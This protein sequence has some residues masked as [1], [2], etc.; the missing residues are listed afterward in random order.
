MA[1]SK[2]NLKQGSK[3]IRRRAHL[4][5]YYTIRRTF[6]SESGSGQRKGKMETCRPRIVEACA[7]A[8]VVCSR[9]TRLSSRPR[10][11]YAETKLVQNA[12][13]RG[14]A[15]R[16]MPTDVVARGGAF[17]A[18]GR[19]YHSDQSCVGIYDSLRPQA[20]SFIERPELAIR[21]SADLSS[22]ATTFQLLFCASSLCC[23]PTLPT[24]GTT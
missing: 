19:G 7:A 11:G 21:C 23:H 2:E 12:D 9:A 3:N 15:P 17:V 22:H 1:I 6:T 4:S 24:K 5:L 18:S 14:R 13:P 20:P 16:M 8:Q 10:L